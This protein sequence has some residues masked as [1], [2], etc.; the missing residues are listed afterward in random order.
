VI[1]PSGP[2]DVEGLERGVA[3]LRERYVVSHRGD[4]TERS[5]FLAGSDDRRATELLEAL[6]DPTVDA[7][8][9]ARGGH[10]ATRILAR[11]AP[12]AIAAAGKLLVGFSDVTALH[13]AWSRAGLRSIHGPM[14]ATLGRAD[15]TLRRRWIEAVE[16]HPPAQLTGLRAL[17]PGRATGPLIGGNLSVLAALVGTP[18]LPPLAGAIL[19]LEDVHE[20][21]Y[22]VDRMLTTLRNAGVLDGVAGIAL[23]AFTDAPAEAGAIESVLAER[24][25]DLGVP[26]LAGIPSGHVEDNLELPLG[27][28]VRLD[29][30]QAPAVTFLEAAVAR[31]GAGAVG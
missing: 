15:A 5:T 22:R 26:V 23:G 8:V 29:A 20:A 6:A 12:S 4:I 7:I 25:G 31:D 28:P 2:F 16:G 10:G 24:L 13:A 9:A 3:W 18:Y 11:V 17:A 19:F 30:G 14:V 27:A 21:P 1:A